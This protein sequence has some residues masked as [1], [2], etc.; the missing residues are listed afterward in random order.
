[1][2]SLE[3]LCGELPAKTV[4]LEHQEEDR[5]IILKWI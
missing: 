3:N 5:K 1:M 2:K 4:I